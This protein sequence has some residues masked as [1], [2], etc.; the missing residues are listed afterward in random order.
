MDESDIYLTRDELGSSVLDGVFCRHIGPHRDALSGV[1]V[2]VQRGVP[3]AS[4][5]VGRFPLVDRCGLRLNAI[6][7]PTSDGYT[8]LR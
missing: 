7:M 5:D 2:A 6:A 1:G 8:D 4:G 3:E